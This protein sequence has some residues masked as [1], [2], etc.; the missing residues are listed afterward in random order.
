MSLHRISTAA[1]AVLALAAPAAF[2][3]AG[4]IDPAVKARVVTDPFDATDCTKVYAGGKYFPNARPHAPYKLSDCRT[5]DF[6]GAIGQ[7]GTTLENPPKELPG[8]SQLPLCLGV[9]PSIDHYLKLYKNK[10]RR[11][12]AGAK[13]TQDL[14]QL[15]IWC[16]AKGQLNKVIWLTNNEQLSVGFA[17]SKIAGGNIFVT[18]SEAC[19]WHSLGKPFPYSGKAKREQA[20]AKKGAARSKAPAKIGKGKSAGAAASSSH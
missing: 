16:A 9:G 5:P 4:D 7:P 14:N 17:K 6:W 15:L 11:L 1:M 12:S 10:C 18:A 2:A 13:W 20:S 8:F 19:L 3:K